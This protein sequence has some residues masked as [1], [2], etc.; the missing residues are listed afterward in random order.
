MHYTFKGRG[1]GV[2]RIVGESFMGAHESFGV[3]ASK[4]DMQIKTNIKML[5]GLEEYFPVLLH[6]FCFRVQIS[7]VSIFFLPHSYA[8]DYMS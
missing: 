5:F 4:N 8:P 6:I 7:A 2:D 1:V 3:Q